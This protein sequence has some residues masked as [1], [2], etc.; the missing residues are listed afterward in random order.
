M[1]TILF[2]IKLSVYSFVYISMDSWFPILFTGLYFVTSV[3]YF[4]IQMVPNLASGSPFKVSPVHL[5][6]VPNILSGLF[7]FLIHKMFQAWNP[8]FQG[9]PVPFNGEGCLEAKVWV[10][11]VFIPIGVLLLLGPSSQTRGIYLYIH[12]LTDRSIAVNNELTSIPPI[13]HHTGFISLSIFVT[14][15][16]TVRNLTPILLG[17]F[18]YL[19]SPTVCD[20]SLLPLLPLTWVDAPLTR[21]GPSTPHGTIV[22]PLPCGHPPHPACALRPR[23]TSPRLRGALLTLIPVCDPPQ[24]AVLFSG[25]DA[26]LAHNCL[27]L[28]L[29]MFWGEK[30]R[31]RA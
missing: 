15:S 23:A 25:V 28:L 21:S 13:Q 11:G 17:I 7:N 27:R 12:Q 29:W 8:I 20:R 30:K 10:L 6:H 5:W 18:V 4:K 3:I 22:T 19:T 26:S 14:P 16:P 9:A 2:L 24:A 1:G 31:G